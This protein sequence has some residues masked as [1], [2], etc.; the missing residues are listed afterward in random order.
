LA[1]EE[2]NQFKAAWR[3]IAPFWFS[4]QKW[5][6]FGLLAC[7]AAAAIGSTYVSV[8][9]NTWSGEQM[10]ALVKYDESAY[11]MLLRHL[12]LILGAFMA[13]AMIELLARS[14]LQI[15]WRTWL[16]NRFLGRWLTRDTLYRI[17]R[18]QLV[19]NPDQRI[20][21]D[22]DQLITHAFTLTVD[23]LITVGRLSSFSVVLWSLSG[24]LA[25]VGA[26][27]TW[28]I[29]GYMFWVA[30]VYSGLA[31]GI[32][33]LLGRSLMPLNFNKQRAE[34]EFRFMMVGAREYA[35]Q[36]ALYHGSS[37]EAR[38]MR[39]GFE[40]VR[41]N[42]WQLVHVRLRLTGAQAVWSV[43]GLVIPTICTAPR[44][45]SRAI[46][47]G[48]VTQIGGAFTIVSAALSW[49][50]HNYETVQL[51]RVVVRRLHGLELATESA[52]RISGGVD[53]ATAPQPTLTVAD[54]ALCTPQGA[55]L[56]KGLTLA[57]QPGERWLIKGES[58]VGKS[59][60]VRALAGIW[61]YGSGVIRMPSTAKMLFLSQ[62]NY[63]PPGTLKAAVCY[64]S[65]ETAFDDEACRQALLDA[66]LP[67]YTDQLD[68]IDRWG[69]RLSPG[70]QQ[71]LAMAR[72]LLQ[73]PTF[74]FLDE[75]TSALDPATERA[76]YTLLVRQLPYTAIVHVSHRPSLDEFHGHVLQMTPIA[77]T[78][79]VAA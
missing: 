39:A 67:A 32:T 41:Q 51:F 7:V 63:V 3:L 62:K 76:V 56:N 19:D 16:T 60:L 2:G 49:F 6:A 33:H 75:S 13:L 53:Y 14:A 37:T 73:R 72:A 61:P 77:A 5:Q 17:E 20:T 71:R 9:F 25:F 34:A 55:L 45:F 43:L 21:E 36:I 46:S 69:Q 29:P 68:E 15:L 40:K 4:E 30:V 28:T 70:E 47:L 10:D 57:V 59:T 66:R 65:E 22:I 79:P 48:G 26:G 12:V 42:F 54:L 1:I 78:A 52:G 23:L 35:E 24:P 11:W 27:R 31:T 64:P 74:L 38:R 18:E 8:G 50:V 44:Y 58:G